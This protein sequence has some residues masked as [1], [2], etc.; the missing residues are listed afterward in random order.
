[1]I[2]ED[3]CQTMLSKKM[4]VFLNRLS[5]GDRAGLTIGKNTYLQNLHLGVQQ[6]HQ[7]SIGS[8]CSFGPNVAIK[9]DGVRGKMQFTQYPIHLIDANAHVLQ[10]QKEITRNLFVTIG[11]DCF[12]GE[13]CRI[14]GNVT[15]GDGVIIGERSLVPFGKRLE[16]FGIYVG[17]PVKLVGY[18]YDKDI[19]AEILRIQWWEWPLKKIQ[20]S[21]LQHIDFISQK[22]E[23]KKKLQAIE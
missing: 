22:E 9:L 8:F 18:R 7:V 16:P 6:D 3:G 19:I 12:I 5:E 1:M 15:I 10:K 23:V 11:N 14:M 2:F 20:E 17:Q 21:G 13:D 4:F